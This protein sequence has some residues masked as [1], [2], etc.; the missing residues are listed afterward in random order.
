MFPFLK[1]EQGFE[2]LTHQQNT[3]E[4]KDNA[5][6][7]RELVKWTRNL[8]YTTGALA[9][10]TFGVACFAGWQAWE[11]RQ[12]SVDTGRLAAAATAQATTVQKELELTQ[13]PWMEG[14]LQFTSP[15]RIDSDGAHTTVKLTIKNTGR[16]P[17]IT[18]WRTS[19]IFAGGNDIETMEQ[20]E[21]E[22]CNERAPNVTSGRPNGFTVFPKTQNSSEGL[23]SIDKA[24]ITQARRADGMVVLR[25]IAC[26]NY[27]YSFIKSDEWHQTSYVWEIDKKTPNGVTATNANDD[28]V[29]PG[30]ILMQNHPLLPGRAS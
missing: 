7:Q 23:L 19:K 1:Q 2:R 27:K 12:G 13:R 18:V 21:N 16:T 17:A 29:Q 3:K 20:W 30:D 28:I 10:A 22:V 24:T 9:A 25:I 4:N 5:A 15:L 14:E 11:M 8:A 6:H 26:I